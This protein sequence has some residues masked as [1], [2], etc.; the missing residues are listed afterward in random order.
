MAEF[1]PV[2]VVLPPQRRERLPMAVERA[3]V[4]HGLT[5]QSRRVIR[6]LAEAQTCQAVTVIW[7]A[8]PALVV[9]AG[10]ALPVVRVLGRLVALAVKR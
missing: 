3:V 2:V 9:A 4:A 10:G 1:F 7:L 5:A 8:V 6:A